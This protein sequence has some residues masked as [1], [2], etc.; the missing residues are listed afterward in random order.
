MRV[1]GDQRDAGQ[2]ASGGIPEERQLPGT[3][4]AGGDLQAQDLPV[5]LDVHP[6]RYQGVHVHRPPCLADLQHQM[7]TTTG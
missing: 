5:P 3:A 2:P 6:A 7:S 4:L 1:G